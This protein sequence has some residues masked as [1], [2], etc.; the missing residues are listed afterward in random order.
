[1]FSTEP[2]AATAFAVIVGMETV[3]LEKFV[4]G[5]IVIVGVLIAQS[6]DIIPALRKNTQDS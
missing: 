6:E 4:L 2:V 3:S 1:M 5:G